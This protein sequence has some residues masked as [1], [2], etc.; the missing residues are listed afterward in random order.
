MTILVFGGSGIVGQALVPIL[1]A[2]GAKV[3]V[4]TRSKAYAATLPDDIET[5]IADMD[6]PPT[7]RRAFDRVESV[8]L[9]LANGPQETQQGLATLAIAVEAPPKHIVYLSSGLSARAPI[10]PHAG[11][12]VAIEAALRASGI[13]YTVLR[14]SFFAQ[15]DLVVKDAIMA[16][17]Y[18]TPLGPHPVAR[19]DSRDVALAAAT[20]LLTVRARNET[21]DLSSSDAPNGVETAA[22]WSTALGRKVVYPDLS[23]EAFADSVQ[24]MLP[25]W[26]NFDLLI[27]HRWFKRYGFPVGQKDLEAQAA[28]LPDGPRSYASFV[29]QTV[30][31]WQVAKETGSP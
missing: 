30:A 3:R 8:F 15:N 4:V 26:L 11:S 2:N 17:A 27:M 19:V 16:G 14:P 29:E 28:L 31:A 10:V 5:V 24:S 9:L 12:K 1:Y 25:P 18:P 22:L 23:P 21:F 7:L 6:D 13:A 20:A